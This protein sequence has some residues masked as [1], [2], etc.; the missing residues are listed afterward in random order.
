MTPAPETTTATPAI[1]YTTALFSDAHVVIRFHSG[2]DE[3]C[4]KRP[5]ESKAVLRDGDI[6]TGSADIFAITRRYRE[7][8]I[9]RCRREKES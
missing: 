4:E 1:V 6:G 5:E 7:E 8:A 3:D 2:K 9:R